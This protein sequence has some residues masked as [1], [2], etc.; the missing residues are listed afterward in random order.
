MEG[1]VTLLTYSYSLGFYVWG[2]IKAHICSE[3]I[4]TIKH[5]KQK[6]QAEVESVS[7]E[8]LIEAREKVEFC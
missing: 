7:A 6:I 8:D 5:L 4:Q 2:Y 3:K 1:L